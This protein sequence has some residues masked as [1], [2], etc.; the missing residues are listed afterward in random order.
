M[1]EVKEFKTETKRL[2]DLMINSIYTN[3]E[4]FLR[5]LISNASDA[6]DKYHYLSLT[7]EA[8]RTSDEYE[9]MVTPDE[10]ART[11]S[12]KDNG[13][14][15]TYDEVVNNLG[16][17]AKSG[18]LDFIK[19]MEDDKKNEVDIIGQFGVGFY[20]GFMVADK[21]EVLTKSPY[22]EKGYKFTSS[23]VDS[24]EIDEVDGL[25]RGTEII[26]YLR[27]ST[28]EEDY[29]KFLKTYEI[30]ELVKKYSDY[31]RYPIKMYITKKEPKKDEEGKTIEGEYNDITELETLNSMIPIWKKSKSE[32]TDEELNEF[33]KSKFY[34]Y[35]DPMIKVFTSVEGSLTYN[36]LVFIP[37]QAP[38]NLY[39]DKYEKGLQLYTKGVF[40]M[41]KCKEL[42]P[43][44]LRFCKGLVDSSDLSLNIS[45][46]ILQQTTE[47]TK[48]AKNVEKK[49][50][51][52]LGKLRDND[53]AKYEEFFKA[54]GL[55]LKYGI[56][57]NYGEKKD[58]LKDLI[59]FRSLTQ[60]K[61][62]TLEEYVK[63]M[64]ED[65]KEIYYASG[66]SVEAVKSLPQLDLVK[67]KGYDVLVLTDDVDEFMINILG[68]YN[69]HKFKS[70]N[71]GDLDLMNE[72]DKKALDELK[73]EKKPL[74][75]KLK[76]AL[77]D[78]CKDV[79]ISKRLTESPVCLVSG[80]GVSFEMEKVLS[81]MPNNPGLSASRILE[82]NPNHDLFKAIEYVNEN[83]PELLDDFANLLYNQALLIEGM[84]LKDP[85]DFSN[86]MCKLMV[87][88]ANK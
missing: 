29:D 63:D 2:L 80:E 51:A 27:Q 54:Y 75:E 55:N 26:L 13:I 24:Y 48:I 83:K 38:Y 22:S 82:I 70:I 62:I 4:I 86:K 32:V 46:E 68:E 73:E 23:G 7:D 3:K 21:I 20:S 50:L 87:L 49:I 5:E 60:D 9:I 77:K 67:S 85:V 12:I 64:K 17:I 88:F 52:E 15:M 44:Y 74:L 84:P 43:D 61:M 58:L 10:K 28:E 11:I 8:I 76:E 72:E 56:Y 59:L 31:V 81:N 65:Q 33:Y 30:K 37:A 71:Q 39:S 40:I 42:I 69:E 47:L 6:I 66:Q 57:E 78:E 79:V 18:S 41:D 1:S 16:T 53:R 25:S 19:K 35:Q 45:R 14:G 36:A 34:D